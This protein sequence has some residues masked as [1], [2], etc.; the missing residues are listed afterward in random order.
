[1]KKISNIKAFYID[2]YSQNSAHE[3]FNASL[4]LMCSIIF[5]EVDC[6]ISKSAYQNY[7]KIIK[8]PSPENVFYKNTF[9]VEGSSRMSLILRYLVSAIQNIK[10][11]VFSPKDAILIFPFNNLF[12]LRIVNF[13]NKFCNRRILIFCHSEMEGIIT[14]TKKGGFLHKILTRLS[15]NFFL[16]G[17]IKISKDLYFSVLGDVLKENISNII[18]LSKAVKFISMD[19]P[20]LFHNEELT[21]DNSVMLSIGTVGA[22]SKTKGLYGFIEFANKIKPSLRG[23]MNISVVGTTH[24]DIN[25]LK[26]AKIEFFSKDNELLS[27]E[28]LNHR[29]NELDYMLF[30]YPKDSYRITASGAIMDA[31]CYEKPIIALKNDY[32]EYLFN[33]YGCFGFLFED[34]DSMVDK[35]EDI[36]INNLK[37]KINFKS[38]KEKFYPE[39]ISIE[40]ENELKRIG[41]IKK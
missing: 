34:I 3:M 23:G 12:S 21:K 13:I 38:L 20:Y 27:R 16:N 39:V 36:S 10:Y 7:L 24:E 37:S 15:H 41:F 18:D 25:L 14:N 6:R 31:I 33:K 29:I 9:V 4:I 30:F 5:E 28:E 19:H 40:L 17:K 22:I 1:M 2:T 8:R 35:I 32:F 26:E 11:L